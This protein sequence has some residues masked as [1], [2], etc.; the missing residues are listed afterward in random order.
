[1]R[2]FERDGSDVLNT[3]EYWEQ[4]MQLADKMPRE[5]EIDVEAERTDDAGGPSRAELGTIGSKAAA[6]VIK[7]DEVMQAGPEARQELDAWLETMKG[8]P[9]EYWHKLE[10]KWWFDE[11]APL[12]R[13]AMPK[14]DVLMNEASKMLREQVPGLSDE[15]VRTRAEMATKVVL[16]DLAKREAEM[17]IATKDKLDRKGNRK[18]DKGWDEKLLHRAF[19]EMRNHLMNFY[20]S[21][22]WV[23]DGVAGDDL[24]EN[25][26]IAWRTVV[27]PQ[28]PGT[29]NMR[30]L[31]DKYPRREEEG[32][33]EYFARLKNYTR[34][35]KTRED[36]LAADAKYEAEHPQPVVET[37]KKQEVERPTEKQETIRKLRPDEAEIVYAPVPLQSEMEQQGTRGVR[38]DVEA[39]P[40]VEDVVEVGPVLKTETKTEPVDEM[41]MVEQTLDMA[42]QVA[43]VM[44]QDN[45]VL[46]EYNPAKAEMAGMLDELAVLLVNIQAAHEASKDD[47]AEGKRQKDLG[48]VP[49]RV[50]V[51]E[52]DDIRRGELALQSLYDRGYLDRETPARAN[53]A[54]LQE[55]QQ[56]AE[57]GIK[58]EK[59]ELE[60]ATREAARVVGNDEV[61]TKRRE[62]AR[63]MAQE[64][65]MRQMAYSE[66]LE[67]IL[68]ALRYLQKVVQEE[69]PADDAEHIVEFPSEEVLEG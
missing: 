43:R 64:A 60:R 28:K 29:L 58:S 14:L 18:L 26:Q 54:F 27:E 57:A 36:Q 15:G 1:M 65:R 38:Q 55:F 22:D 30:I 25:E 69:V 52:S 49:D 13:Y 6:S 17:L 67:K 68:P 45:D 50:S 66:L 48:L 19:Y 10:D 46:E 47:I 20:K 32:A 21:Y 12:D 63:D 34:Q 16:Q 31:L 59:I 56:R 42:Q 40:L 53:L 23:R 62:K 7:P 11:E 51:G 9:E 35:D 37:V 41:T 39:L 44:K 61:N 8:S 2:S 4:L 3:E 5:G 24:T 33:D